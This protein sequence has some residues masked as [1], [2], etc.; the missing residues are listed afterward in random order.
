[1]ISNYS[2]MTPRSL[3]DK[4]QIFNRSNYKKTYTSFSGADIIATIDIP[5]KPPLVIGELQTISYSIHREVIPVRTI[6]R[7]NP[8]GFVSGQRTIA[9]SLIFT[10]F[11]KNLVYQFKD[12]LRLYCSTGINADI[13]V[14]TEFGRYSLMDEMPPF[15]INIIFQNEYGQKSKITIENVVIVDEGQIMSIEDMITENTMSYVATDIKV[16]HIPEDKL[17]EQ[18]IETNLRPEERW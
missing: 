12:W 8:V 5:G 2:R 11:D 6:G 15:N 1:M 14:D 18:R 4:E 10:V 3:A 7:A 9:G 17:Y 13:N 16:M